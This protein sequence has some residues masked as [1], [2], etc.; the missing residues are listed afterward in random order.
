MVPLKDSGLETECYDFDERLLTFFV[1]NI[2]GNQFNCLGTHAYVVN[3]FL[4]K[5]TFFVFLFF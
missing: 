5:F 4:S 1:T 3:F 2:Y